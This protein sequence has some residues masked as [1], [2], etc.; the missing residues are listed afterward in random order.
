[1]YI[2]VGICMCISRWLC[3]H[4]HIYVR[5][6]A[7]LFAASGSAAESYKVLV[8][9]VRLKMENSMRGEGWNEEEEGTKQRKK[10]KIK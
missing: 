6:C 3:V 4:V 7:A 1:M 8:T 5:M 2:S 9:E 10:N